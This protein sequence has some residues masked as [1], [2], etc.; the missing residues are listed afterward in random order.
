M[1]MQLL[2]NKIKIL[3]KGI[4]KYTAICK[5]QVINQ[6]AYPLDLVTQ[7]LTI[8]IFMWIFM[9]L[10]KTTYRF[11]QKDIL[12]GLSLHDTLWY[13]MLAET[14]MLSKPRLS[15]VIAESVRDGSIAYQL[16]KPYHYVLYHLSV[17]FGDNLTRMVFYLISGGCIVW[18]LVGPPPDPHGWPLVLIAMI[19]GWMIDFCINILI[20]LAA[21]LVEEVSAFDWIYSKFLL[22]LGG[23]LIPLDFFPSWLRSISQALPFANTIYGP[24]RLFVDPTPERFIHLLGGQL[25]WLSVFAV[26]VLICYNRGAKYLTINGG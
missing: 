5:T 23:I 3:P 18:I 4:L 12:N 14:I 26:I 22:L 24:A 16:N 25:A 1:R 17:A 13:L 21:F 11:A 6:L 20:G 15:R 10:W 19:I 2:L 8:V 7:S 9:Q